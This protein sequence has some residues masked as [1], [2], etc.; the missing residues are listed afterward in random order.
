MSNIQINK[1]DW[2]I[3]QQILHKYPYHFYVYGSRAKGTAR[4]FSDLDICYYDAPDLV[5][6]DIRE[7]LE[8][9]DLPFIVELVAWKNMRPAFQKNIKKDLV[10]ISPHE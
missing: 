1:V 6:G 7:E 2:K 5:I 10:L 4:K 9:S 3:L 8:N